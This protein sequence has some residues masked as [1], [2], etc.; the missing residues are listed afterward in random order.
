MGVQLALKKADAPF[1]QPQ[2]YTA[3]RH[4]LLCP[5]LPPTEVVLHSLG[6][7]QMSFIDCLCLALPEHLPAHHMY[8]VYI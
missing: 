8:W 2:T 4:P 6:C 3:H 7:S 1:T 5:R